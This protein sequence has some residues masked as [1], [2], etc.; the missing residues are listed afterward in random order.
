MGSRAITPK[1]S[2]AGFIMEAPPERTRVVEGNEVGVAGVR[3]ESVVQDESLATLSIIAE[4]LLDLLDD[5][6]GGG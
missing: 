2:T 5:M 6:P 1:T 4:E 3:A